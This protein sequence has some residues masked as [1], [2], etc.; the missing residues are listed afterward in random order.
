MRNA[1][2]L[3]ACVAVLVLVNWSILK[4][5]RLLENGRVV[6]LELAPVD[7][8]SLMQGDYMALQFR[9]AADARADV[10]RSH[11]PRPAEG[12]EPATADGRIVVAL[13][14]RGIATYRRLDDGKPLAQD[15]IYL[16]YRVR[17]GQMKF[18]TNAYF[19]EERT[20]GRYE[21]AR[22]GEF[23]VAN[24]GD[25]LLTRLRGKDLEPL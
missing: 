3:I 13:D 6:H 20:A 1:V 12:N 19:F 10:T 14:A 15:E 11:P 18:A 24:D 21:P 2:A 23:R 8:R 5:E 17:D 22:Y 25:L 9:V 7:P 4:K 16:R